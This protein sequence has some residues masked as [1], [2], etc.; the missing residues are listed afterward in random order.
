V[1]ENRWFDSVVII[2]LLKKKLIS[3]I[4]F[5]FKHKTECDNIDQKESTVKRSAT[6][7]QLNKENQK[8]EH[9]HFF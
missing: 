9:F 6:N 1:N 8:R 2:G 7:D 4:L 3:S 5:F